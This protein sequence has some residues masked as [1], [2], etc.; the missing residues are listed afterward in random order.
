M[1][2]DYAAAQ[3]LFRKHKGLLTR[4]LHVRD[5]K[6]RRIAVLATCKQFVADFAA[7]D[8]PWPDDWARWQRALDD[9]Y[10]VFN[11]P[12]LEDLR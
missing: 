1:P 5:V 9:Q 10:P 3:K 6:A 8:A 11:S 2:I 4:A 7:I 12:R